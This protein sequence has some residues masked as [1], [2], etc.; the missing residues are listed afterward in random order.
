[1]HVGFGWPL[2]EP[3]EDVVVPP[4]LDP[5]VVVPLDEVAPLEDVVAPDDPEEDD[6]P[7]DDD[8]VERTSW[9]DAPPHATTI[10]PTDPMKANAGES[11]MRPS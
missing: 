8:D 9:S 10:I 3:D 2:L 5:E 6:V 1:M 11:R 7:E 4:P